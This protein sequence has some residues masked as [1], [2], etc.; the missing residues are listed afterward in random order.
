MNYWMIGRKRLCEIVLIL[1]C[2]MLNIFRKGIKM[3]AKFKSKL[4]TVLAISLFLVIPASANTANLTW[5]RANGCTTPDSTITG[6][7]TSGTNKL[8]QDDDGGGSADVSCNTVLNKSGSTDTGWTYEGGDDEIDDNA[9]AVAC[10]DAMTRDCVALT[11]ITYDGKSCT[12]LSRGSKIIISASPGSDTLVHE[13][14]HTAGLDDLNPTVYRR[15]MNYVSS[16]S[17][18][19]VIASERDSYEGL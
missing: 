9:E 6:W 19:R 17:N 18:C 13:V 10:F 8:C 5:H 4:I 11:S 7:H 12:G 2:L 3:L 1:Y 15:I 16:D 14:G